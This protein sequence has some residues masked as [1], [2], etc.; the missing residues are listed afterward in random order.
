MPGNTLPPSGGS[1]W[2]E[3]IYITLAAILGRASWHAYEVQQKNRRFLSWLLIT[4]L[5]IAAAMAMVGAGVCDYYGLEGQVKY[6]VIGVLAHLG[7]GGC[8]HLAKP[9]LKRWSKGGTGNV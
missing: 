5:I 4:D 8:H 9:F 6:A 1:G 2:W 7:P 3:I